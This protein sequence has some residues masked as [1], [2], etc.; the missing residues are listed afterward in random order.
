MPSVNQTL[1]SGAGGDS[2][3][4]L[5]PAMPVANSVTVPV[6]VIRP[7]WLPN[8][9]VYHRLPSGPVVIA[10]GSPPA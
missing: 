9:S 7:I 4:S 6:G 8:C 2:G 10:S 1:P 3:D 5:T